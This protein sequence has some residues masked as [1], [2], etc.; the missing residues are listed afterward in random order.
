MDANS[1]VD[2]VAKTKRLIFTVTTGRSGTKYLTA[3]LS[4]VPGVCSLHEPQPDFASYMRKCQTSPETA[5]AF[6][7]HLKLPFIA[8]RPEP[9]YA[10][11][12]HLF[13]K[14]FLESALL[15]GLRPKLV[16]LSRSP[17]E[18]A[19]SL[20]E[21]TT[22]PA[23]TEAGLKYLISPQ[24]PNVMPLI[25]WESMTDYQLC[26]WYALEIERRQ[27]RYSEY[28]KALGLTAVEVLQRNLGN[29]LQYKNMLD[30]LEL[31]ADD[32]VMASHR[33]MSAQQ[34]NRNPRS[35][36]KPD[37]L[38]AQESDVWRAVM[39]F[40]PFLA[41]RIAEKYAIRESIAA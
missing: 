14:G 33:T 16:M 32:A 38:L 25:G 9:V 5:F 17:S 18:V 15:L 3:L 20:L 21:R 19:W 31:P 4:T 39:C 41:D 37:D 10:E 27:I 1:I 24:D 30:A 13:C 23:R 11:A 35:L 7:L 22:V 26:F 40:E 28:A 34:H 2:R 12:S 6:W 29:P 8:S 36:A